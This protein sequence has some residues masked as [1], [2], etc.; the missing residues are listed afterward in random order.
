MDL[1]IK[2]KK[3]IVN[4]G[5]SGMGR[6]AV[7]ALA[8]EGVEIF[9]SARGEGRLVRSCEEI[10]QLTDALIT[11]IVADHS[12]DKGRE[13]ILSLC[14]EPD[15]FVGTCAPP[16]FTG[17]FHSVSKEAWTETLS[18]AL[19]SPVQF[20]NE[21]L[22]GMCDRKWGRVVNIATAAAKYPS[23]A[24]ILS[25]P[26]RAALVNYTV[27]VSKEVAKHNVCVNNILPGMHITDPIIEMFTNIAKENG[28]TMDAEIINVCNDH[29]IAAGR[30]GDPDDVGSVVAMLCSEFSNYITGQSLIIDG[31]VTNSTF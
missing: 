8:K 17:D 3:A 21:I 28:T 15:I 25:G 18:I 23:A 2:G 31:G 9:V 10:S 5:S 27:A 22:P 24:R 26:P 14:P 30:F 20:M 4:G 6:G 1:G 11:P 13:L 19:Q 12:T 7:L 16:T 29:K